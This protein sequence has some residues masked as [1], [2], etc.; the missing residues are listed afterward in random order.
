LIGLIGVLI[1]SVFE[2]R[3]RS[4]KR[5]Q[6]RL[7]VE[8]EKRTHEL[9][10]SNRLLARSNAELEQFAYVASHDL[11]EPLRMVSSYMGLLSK[12]YQDQL[13]DDA[14]EFIGFAVDGSKRMQQLI[15][16]LLGY[17]R[18]ST[19]GKPFEETNCEEAFD[20]AAQN[21]KL[22]VEESGAKVT[23]DALPTVMADR[24]Q[25][26]RL[27]QN[28]IGNAIKYQAKEAVPAVHV[29]AKRDGDEWVIS[30]RDNGIGID[31]KYSERIFGIFQRLHTRDQY[32]G[33]GIGL[34]VCKKIVERHKGRIWVE[35]E[36]GKGATFYFTLPADDSEGGTP[37][38][39]S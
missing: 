12:R 26:E 7:A 11:Q 30:V 1:V 16:D 6:E 20:C 3:V 35:S 10:E 23:H 4:I 18:V 22:A 37:Q 17:S 21:L 28:L 5:H 8:V 14:R 32:S 36:E 9:N 39:E 15:N 29:S 31:P 24:V 19:Q 27:F 38:T 25:I 13:D 2:F 33:T 34:A